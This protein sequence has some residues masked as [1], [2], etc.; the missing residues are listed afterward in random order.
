MKI[1]T[2]RFGEIEVADD[3]LID[4]PDGLLGFP[5]CRRF[6]LLDNAQ[7]GAFRW[8]QSMDEGAVAFVVADPWIF[9]SDYRVNARPE[10]LEPIRVANIEAAAVLVIM[11]I[12][13]DAGEI[14]ANLQ[15]PLIMN[16]EARLGRQIVLNDPG[17]TP[18]HKI[19]VGAK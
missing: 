10:D 2:S 19:L 16:A 14:T 12:K 3:R 15:G 5:N 9:F 18:R 6:A 13:R 7:G 17:L 1:K 8:L 4:F 11:S